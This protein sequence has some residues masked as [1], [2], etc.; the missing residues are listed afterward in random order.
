R[1]PVVERIGEGVEVLA[2]VEMPAGRRPVVCAA[3][4]VIT[5]AFHPELDGDARI[6]EL[7]V[8]KVEGG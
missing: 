4:N 8:R 3:G 7:F 1:A 6:H 2:E 5:V